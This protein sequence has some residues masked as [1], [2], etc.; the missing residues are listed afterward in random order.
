MPSPIGSRLGSL[1]LSMPASNA[2][3]FALL[4]EASKSNLRA[5]A[6]SCP[7]GILST[8]CPELLAGVSTLARKSTMIFPRLIVRI[9]SGLYVGMYRS[10]LIILLESTDD[11]SKERQ[12]SVRREPA[13][14]CEFPI[15]ALYYSKVLGWFHVEDYLN[16]LRVFPNSHDVDDVYHELTLFDSES[17]FSWVQLHVDL[18]KVNADLSFE[19][20]GDRSVPIVMGYLGI[21]GGSLRVS[22]R[23][24]S[25]AISP[26]LLS[27]MIAAKLASLP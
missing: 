24:G 25:Y 23:I 2:S 8:N 3:Y 18:S 5:Y 4:F 22:P 12:A 16:L 27:S 26:V 20:L 1:G 10:S 19:L 14:S 7:G 13:E 11:I 15:K 17:T 9:R 6:K 21:Q